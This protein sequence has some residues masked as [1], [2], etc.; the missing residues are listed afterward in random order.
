MNNRT[1]RQLVVKCAFD[2]RNKKIT[3]DSARN[4]TYDVLRRKVEE[5]FALSST[6]FA[7]TY[8]DD[9]GEVTT[10]SNENDLTEAIQY[11]QPGDDPPLSSAASILS[12]RSFGSRRVTLK[13]HIIVEYDGPSLSDTSSLI[14]LDEYRGRNASQ[15]SFTF[16]TPV[17]DDDSVT[18]SSRDT[19]LLRADD[20]SLTGSNRSR[21]TLFRP[22]ERDGTTTQRSTRQFDDPFSDNDEPSTDPRQP[23]PDAPP[24]N[25]LTRSSRGAAWLKD[26]NERH[27]RAML[28]V[29]PEPS[30][31][32]DVSLSLNMEDDNEFNGDLALERDPHGRYYYNYTAGSSGSQTHDSGYDDGLPTAE[33]A[34]LQPPRPSSMHLNWLATQQIQTQDAPIS[35]TSGDYLSNPHEEP[36]FMIDKE[37]LQYLPTTVPPEESLTDCSSCGARLDVIRYVC[38][39]CGEKHPIM[40]SP[41]LKGKGKA[42]GSPTFSYPPHPPYSSSSP[43]NSFTSQTYIGG[44]SESLSTYYRPLPSMASSPN[45]STPG[46]P[47]HRGFELC[48]E[49]LE[50]VGV[51]HAIEAGLTSTSSP[52]MPSLANGDAQAASQWRRAAPKKGELRHAFLEK[53]WSHNRWEDVVHELHPSHAFLNVP[54]RPFREP[55]TSPHTPDVHD[56]QP[57]KHPGVKCAHCLQ[58]IVGARFHCAECDFVDICANCESAG[59]PG[60]LDSSDGGHVSSHILI[61]IPYP[62][63]MTETGSQTHR[64]TL[65]YVTNLVSLNSMTSYPQNSNP[66]R[67]REPVGFNGPHSPTNPAA[68]LITLTHSSSLCDRCMEPIVGAWFRCAYCARDLCD[69]CEAVDTHNDAHVFLVFKALVDMKTLQRLANLE[70]PTESP[71][72][73]PYAIY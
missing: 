41:T 48:A 12:G 19:S 20:R 38:S 6:L 40:A 1:S 50:L 13:V 49:C 36:D 24:T 56:E 15:Q 4:C 10:I 5:C 11:F 17:V 30:V 18:V 47:S 44:S 37:L 64:K 53:C 21:F 63:E 39:T 73:I 32:D 3:F 61:K 66:W 27:I 29:L 54:D 28:G 31:T 67:Y 2:T 60:N 7:I 68:H 16:K 62:L 65:R 59:L 23:L 42:N 33:V 45:L 69:A 9:D 35:D 8:K 14:S 43:A 51:H 58:D 72:I 26:Q 70:N 46:V 55:D 52:T 71:P 34:L 25:T 22:G 57:L